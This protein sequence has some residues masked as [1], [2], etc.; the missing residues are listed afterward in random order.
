MSTHAGFL[1][2]ELAEKV[3][4]CCRVGSALVSVPSYLDQKEQHVTGALGCDICRKARV[5]LGIR[6]FSFVPSHPNSHAAVGMTI[7]QEGRAIEMRLLGEAQ[8]L[9]PRLGGGGKVG[10]S[11]LS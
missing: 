10:F 8:R 2:R 7:S 4:G 5:L 6:M 1:C 9:D 11:V 3:S